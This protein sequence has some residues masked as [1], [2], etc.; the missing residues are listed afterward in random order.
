MP[1]VTKKITD[2]EKAAILMYAFGLLDNW[3]ECYIIAEDKSLQDIA[4]LGNIS[5][6]VTRWRYSEKVVNQLKE[7]QKMINDRIADE[8]S[9]A[10][11]EER[12]KVLAELQTQ[13]EQQTT[14][15][16]HETD[17]R[18]DDGNEM[19][20]KRTKK[21]IKPILTGFVDYADPANQRRKLNELVNTA[22]DPGAALDALK[23]II[24]GQKD[25]RQAAR[26]QKQVRAY[27]PQVC[28][29]CPL[30]TKAAAKLE[31]GNNI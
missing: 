5:P 21:P 8:R 13:A 20:S 1:S 18:Q 16:D 26:E 9:A 14:G 31:K 29:D 24:S 27:L 2:R 12:E 19:G 15:E 17:T 28:Q 4:K 22:K 7:Y 30:Y 11:I 3:K 23:V 10:R 25:D 6:M